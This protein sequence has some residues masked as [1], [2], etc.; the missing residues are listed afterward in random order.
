MLAE[1]CLPDRRE[2][3]ACP[4]GFQEDVHSGP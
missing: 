2:K 1:H 3:C 4:L